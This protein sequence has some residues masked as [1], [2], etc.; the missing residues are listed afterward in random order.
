MKPRMTP[1][2]FSKS[3]A[4]GPL[5]TT[6][7]TR[8]LVAV[9]R[10]EILQCLDDGWPLRAIWERMKGE[11]LLRVGYDAFRRAAVRLQRAKKSGQTLPSTPSTPTSF[12]FNP[13]PNPKEL[14]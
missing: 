5:T 11:G 3:I 1:K 8:A 9:Y 12:N 4:E 13:T 10:D 2:Q 6:R 7:I 14:F